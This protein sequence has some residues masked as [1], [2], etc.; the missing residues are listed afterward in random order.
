[1]IEHLANPEPFGPWARDID[2]EERRCRWRALAALALVYCG[3]DSE[4]AQA[5]RAA[6][7]DDNA[8]NGPGTHSWHCRQYRDA[9]C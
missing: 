1:M 2:Q 5:A 3:N 9:D 4:P 8:A 6:E 7:H